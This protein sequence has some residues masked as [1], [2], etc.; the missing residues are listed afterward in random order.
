MTI[1]AGRPELGDNNG[2][3]AGT[4][5]GNR[6]FGEIRTLLRSFS[7]T[8]ITEQYIAGAEFKKM[9]NP[10]LPGFDVGYQIVVLFPELRMA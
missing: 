7:G 10:H 2:R 4:G 9:R 1:A 5:C 3:A 6:H 8:G